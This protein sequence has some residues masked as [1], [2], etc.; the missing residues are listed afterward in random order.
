MEE[1]T[2]PIFLEKTFRDITLIGS[3]AYGK[4]YSG[5]R[6]DDN[7]KYAIKVLIV[8]GD[9]NME[10]V[11]G[12]VRNLASISN[13]TYIVRYY[14]TWIEK[15]T[16]DEYNKLIA[17]DHNFDEESF[18]DE[19]F[20]GELN[21]LDNDDFDGFDFDCFDCD[22]T[23]D[24]DVDWFDSKDEES[25]NNG[26]SNSNEENSTS[27]E[28]DSDSNSNSD[29]NSD[30]N[31]D[32]NS[33]E[34]E[35]SSNEEICDNDKYDISKMSGLTEVNLTSVENEM[36]DANA[37]KYAV[38]IQMEYCSNGD[39]SEMIR[40]RE[41]HYSTAEGKN[42]VNAYFKQIVSGV[43]TIHERSIIHAD[44]KP[45]NILRGEIKC[46]ILGT[47]GYAAPEI[48]NGKYDNKID[49][50]SLG[51][52][53]YEM[54]LSPAT[55]SEF[56]FA[57][58]QL[59]NN[60][61][62][63]GIVENQYQVY[64]DL[65]IAMTQ[66]NPND[67]PTI[68]E[69][70]RRLTIYD[71]EL[72]KISHLLPNINENTNL[73]PQLSAAIESKNVKEC[74]IEFHEVQSSLLINKEGELMAL[75]NNYPEVT[76]IVMCKKDNPSSYFIRMSTA[77]LH[78]AQSPTISPSLI[79]IN[80][81]NSDD[82]HQFNM[83]E[84][85]TL[86]ISLIPTFSL[87]CKLHV[88]HTFINEVIHSNKDAEK[89][90]LQHPIVPLQQIMSIVLKLTNNNPKINAIA[91]VF[92]CLYDKDNV[93]YDTSL[94][95]TG[96]DGLYYVVKSDGDVLISGNELNIHKNN[97]II[98]TIGYW[99]DV[100]RMEKRVVSGATD[101][102]GKESIKVYLEY[103]GFAVYFEPNKIKKVKF[104]IHLAVSRN[105]RCDFF[106]N[107][108]HDLPAILTIFF[109]NT[110]IYKQ[111]TSLGMALSPMQQFYKKDSTPIFIFEENDL[112]TEV[113]RYLKFH[114]IEA[115][116]QQYK[117]SPDSKFLREIF[118]FKLLVKDKSK[119][120]T[121]KEDLMIIRTCFV[122]ELIIFSHVCYF[123]S[124]NFSYIDISS[125][126]K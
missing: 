34:E 61:K 38:C 79:Y 20:N 46:K 52:I 89:P 7:K 122:I 68:D 126:V 16:Q 18:V 100:E 12:E 11:K 69:I 14:E 53:L 83:I 9:V 78:L 91:P 101:S 32:S 55:R 98:K 57:L 75:L 90:F 44:L 67:R 86:L 28:E 8:S 85:I 106:K 111:T 125:H 95:S 22:D 35:S 70:F 63:S 84:T 17:K 25:N 15:L 74:G 48:L 62:V 40:N 119:Q 108:F 27:N 21:F 88:S 92:A 118:Q 10:N 72:K 64:T 123:H 103:F 51:V 49:V 97:E 120:F 81:S 13:N 117:H 96:M 42:K 93:E 24:I 1:A 66:P 58:D 26:D 33:N 31:S 37:Q 19:S 54:C 107:S 3:G 102:V 82:Q 47:I 109:N 50:Y 87:K 45:A 29:S 99:I 71:E 105:G 41:L 73:W 59:K 4:V 114:G 65:I 2:H 6:T 36:D 104:W 60:H 39:L 23:D 124:F 80:S 112:S 77:C 121:L 30:N 5:I 43:A 76:K 94:P 56:I 115:T 116:Q 110:P 113:W